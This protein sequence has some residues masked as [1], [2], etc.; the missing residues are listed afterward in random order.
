M[1][2]KKQTIKSKEAK[3]ST[4]KKTNGKSAAKAAVTALKKKFGDDVIN[5]M[6]EVQNSPMEVVST[7]SIS[8]DSALGVGGIVL[9]RIYELYGPNASGKTTLAL[10]II[11]EACDKGLN[12]IYVDAEFTLDKKLMEKMGIDTNRVAIIRGYTAE[13]NLDAAKALMSTGDFSLCVIDSVSALH[14]AAEANLESF[15]DNTMGVQPRLMARMCRDFTGLSARTKT[16][17]ILINQIRANLSGY[18][19][20]ETTSGGNAMKHH[21]SGRISVRGGGTKSNQIK[22]SRGEVIGH[23]V[24]FE[25][26]KNKMAAPF[27]STQVDLIYGEGFDRNGELFDLAVDMGFIDQAGSWFSFGEEKLGQGRSNALEGLIANES[28]YNKIQ[29]NVRSL[30]NSSDE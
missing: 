23:K 19:K 30:L 5:W 8:L 4:E 24:S 22:G 27:R 6:G 17:L 11:K 15:S 9:G 21:I 14:P 16:A 1:P 25:I 2:K 12:T 20:S 13:E 29:E 10:S 3:T 7:G 28:I 26:T 18:G